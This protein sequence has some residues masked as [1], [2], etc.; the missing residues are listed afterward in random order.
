LISVLA[1]ISLGAA[2]LGHTRMMIVFV[3]VGWFNQ[4]SV[5]VGMYLMFSGQWSCCSFVGSKAKKCKLLYF[6]PLT[7]VLADLPQLD[8]V[9]DG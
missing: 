6:L 5:H 8:D 7:Y 1:E 4:S 2:L 9:K 3:P